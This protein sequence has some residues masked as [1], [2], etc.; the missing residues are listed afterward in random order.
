M[1]SNDAYRTVRGTVD[2]LLRTFTRKTQPEPVRD[3][4]TDLADYLEQWNPPQQKQPV[5]VNQP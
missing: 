1:E 3:A 4:A 2:R 5:E